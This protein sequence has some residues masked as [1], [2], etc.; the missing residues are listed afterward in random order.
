ME[1]VKARVDVITASGDETVRA[2]QQA[3]KTIP[4]VGIVGDM[5]D[6]GLVTS[7]ARPNG[8]TTGAGILA[9]Q[10]D[11]KRQELL[12]EAVPGIRRMGLLADANQLRNAARVEVL[13]EEARA[14]NIELSIHRVARCEEIAAAIDSARASGSAALNIMASPL[15]YANRHLIFDRAAEAHLPTIHE[16]PEMAEEGGFAAYG[17]RLRAD[18]ESC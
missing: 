9:H 3:T 10:L 16:F 17:P 14:H 5:L 8:N 15:F 12:I 7:L 18:P 2:V 1:L 4:I 13:Q 11:G 6:S